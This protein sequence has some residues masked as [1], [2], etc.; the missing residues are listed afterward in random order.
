MMS[1]DA[2]LTTPDG[3]LT[4]IGRHLLAPGANTVGTAA[5]NSIKLAAGPPYLA[6]VTLAPDRKI[7]LQPAPSARK[8]APEHIPGCDPSTP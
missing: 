5:D 8:P 1:V 7:T 3:W 4:L 2:R 6:T